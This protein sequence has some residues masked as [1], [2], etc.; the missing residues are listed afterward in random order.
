[1]TQA[2][3][4]SPDSCMERLTKEVHQAHVEKRKLGPQ[5]IQQIKRDY[6]KHGATIEWPETA[7]T[8]RDAW[9]RAVES[10]RGP[11]MYH[12]QMITDELPFLTN[13]NACEVREALS[14]FSRLNNA[15]KSHLTDAMVLFQWM[16]DEKINENFP[17]H[18]ALIADEIDIFLHACRKKGSKTTP[19]N[20]VWARRHHK[21]LL[22]LCPQQ[23]L[24]D[25]LACP[26][27][28][29]HT[30]TDQLV[31]LCA[32]KTGELL[33]GEE[34]ASLLDYRVDQHIAACVE[35]FEKGADFKNTTCKAKQTECLDKIKE[36]P[37]IEKLAKLRDVPL[38]V[39]V[40]VVVMIVFLFRIVNPRNHFQHQEVLKL[41]N[42]FFNSCSC[43]QGS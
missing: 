32:T 33:F 6:P 27:D 41:L 22:M 2:G 26:Q 20:R 9:W 19:N 28:A 37:G 24:D 16:I 10:N 15:N 38:V 18:V 42:V 43:S 14:F 34:L 30:V 39:V 17:D 1:M 5:R 40:V 36:M 4:S 7:T 11:V 23:A 35:D 12:R 21:K 8:C 3:K 31:S 25:V 29:L 13:P